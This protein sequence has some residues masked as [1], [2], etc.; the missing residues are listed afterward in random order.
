M[1]IC[2]HNNLRYTLLCYITLGFITLSY[3]IVSLAHYNIVYHLTACCFMFVFFSILLSG[4]IFII[5]PYIV[6]F[7]FIVLCRGSF[8]MFL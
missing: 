7:C 2:T 1:Y 3:I 6:I 5:S 4:K 8:F